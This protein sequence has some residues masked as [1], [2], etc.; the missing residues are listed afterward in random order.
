MVQNEFYTE[1][2]TEYIS[3]IIVPNVGEVATSPTLN[4]ILINN[5]YVDKI[6]HKA[7]ISALAFRT[8][9]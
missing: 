1:G 2:C 7:A 9:E 6:K 8:G 3:V 5:K 4:P